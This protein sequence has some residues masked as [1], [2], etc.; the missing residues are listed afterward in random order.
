[1]GRVV[2][3]VRRRYMRLYKYTPTQRAWTF[4]KFFGD[5]G[6]GTGKETIPE[7]IKWVEFS[8]DDFTKDFDGNFVKD[9]QNRGTQG[10]AMLKKAGKAK[11]GKL[12]KFRNAI[13]K[14]QR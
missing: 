2:P 9:T 7:H 11:A 12:K 6:Y 1:M 8:D 3:H 13:A 5:D 10:K 14:S 4:E